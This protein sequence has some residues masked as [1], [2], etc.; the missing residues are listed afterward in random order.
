MGSL[1][2][3]AQHRASFSA[4]IDCIPRDPS[5]RCRLCL[6]FQLNSHTTRT[7]ALHCRKQSACPVQG[8][9]APQAPLTT[10]MMEKIAM[11]P[12]IRDSIFN[13]CEGGLRGAGQAAA[14]RSGDPWGWWPKAVLG[15]RWE[16][17]APRG[18]QS[19]FRASHA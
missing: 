14:R 7:P 6:S 12:L 4:C 11:S 2:P 5:A 8:P 9:S 13:D 17:A 3:C 15:A 10:D 19:C 18:L 1:C 16:M